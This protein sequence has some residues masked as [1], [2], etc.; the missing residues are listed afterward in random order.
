M[1]DGPTMSWYVMETRDDRGT[2]T[3]ALVRSEVKTPP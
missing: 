3:A 1:A 2:G